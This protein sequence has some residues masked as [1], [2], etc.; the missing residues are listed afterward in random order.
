MLVV[1][2]ALA[3][4]DVK[5]DVEVKISLKFSW[6]PIITSQCLYTF[7]SLHLD[8]RHLGWKRR[9]TFEY[10]AYSGP[11]NR[12]NRIHY[13][14]CLY[15]HNRLLRNWLFAKRS[16]QRW[17][18]ST[19][20]NYWKPFK[21]TTRYTLYRRSLILSILIHFIPIHWCIHLSNFEKKSNEFDFSKYHSVDVEWYLLK[22]L[23]ESAVRINGR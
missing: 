12:N 21:N 5:V 7:F 17:I 11:G 1:E 2:D 19:R 6:M 3:V 14:C 4:V 8:W 13:L 22:E 9:E 10:L 18:A 20:N 15:L 23:K 16:L